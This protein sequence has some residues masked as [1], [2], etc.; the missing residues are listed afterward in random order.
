MLA[1]IAGITAEAWAAVAAL[2]SLAVGVIAY[3]GQRDQQTAQFAPHLS[4][5]EFETSLGPGIWRIRPSTVTN[6]GPGHARMVIAMAKIS[7]QPKQVPVQT[8]LTVKG[9]L[10]ANASVRSDGEMFVFFR[11]TEEPGKA[12]FRA[13]VMAVTCWD[14]VGRRHT[15]VHHLLVTGFAPG[16]GV[17]T[18]PSVH[19]GSVTPHVQTVRTLRLTRWLA[20]IL[21]RI[22]LLRG[23][24]RRLFDQLGP[25]PQSVLSIAE[26]DGDDRRDA[27]SH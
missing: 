7:G 3:R 15:F 27:E 9:W 10:A 20:Q 4:V 25:V 22:P 18:A 21:N 26:A 8:P 14:M 13:V 16:L 2:G 6:H 24:A 12:V 5:T 19:L 23:V 11:E 17:A 1:W